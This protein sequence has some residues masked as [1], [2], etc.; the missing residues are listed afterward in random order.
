MIGDVMMI[1]DDQL[2]TV[3][4]GRKCC[5]KIVKWVRK[6]Y[7]RCLWWCQLISWWM[8]RSRRSHWV[9]LGQLG[10]ACVVGVVVLT[11]PILK[12]LWW[13]SLQDRA[14]SVKMGSSRR[15]CGSTMVPAVTAAVKEERDKKQECKRAAKRRSEKQEPESKEPKNQITRN[16]PCR[17]EIPSRVKRFGVPQ[18][19]ARR[20]GAGKEPTYVKESQ[21][22]A[23]IT[24][25]RMWLWCV[26]DSCVDVMDDQKN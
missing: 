11:Y 19:D 5:E 12:L 1:E 7:G 22:V 3:V 9:Q 16:N 4:D 20:E 25:I 24:M 2:M 26:W 23:M 21:V 17:V 15:G 10:G 13:G 18:E 6:C 8:C 14:I